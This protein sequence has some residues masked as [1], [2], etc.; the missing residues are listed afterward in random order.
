MLTSIL[1]LTSALGL[2]LQ[3]DPG[4]LTSGGGSFVLSTLSAAPVTTMLVA[5]VKKSYPDVRSSVVMWCALAAGQLA[6]FLLALA[7]GTPMTLQA[8]ALCVL[9][10]IVAAAT[11]MGVRSA[12]NSADETRAART[13]QG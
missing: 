13:P 9:G 6:S 4:S 8:G 3:L 12:D 11:A 5:M 2:L 10:G 7:L 1:L